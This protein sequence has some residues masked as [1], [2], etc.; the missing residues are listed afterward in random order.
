MPL[1][2]LSSIKITETCIKNL[3]PRHIFPKNINSLKEC[4][5]NYKIYFSTHSSTTDLT[6]PSPNNC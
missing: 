1:V 3:I 6:V 2:R 4:R 5:L